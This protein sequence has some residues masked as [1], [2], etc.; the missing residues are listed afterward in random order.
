MMRLIQVC[1]SVLTCGLLFSAC[2]VNPGQLEPTTGAPQSLAATVPGATAPTVTP[3]NLVSEASPTAPTLQSPQT[4][5][6]TETAVV[7]TEALPT[8]T[9]AGP[10][11]PLQERVKE[12]VTIFY[13][14]PQGGVFPLLAWPPL[15]ILD[16]SPFQSLY[17][18]Q[19]G[20]AY[21]DDYAPR[22]NADGRY[23]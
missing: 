20:Y 4:P 1:T 13:T 5:V 16:Q 2:A 15:P 14:R 9:E 7:P 8:V 11:S 6:S 3:G 18:E 12:Q 23:L 22:L 10:E 21:L 19:W 17:G